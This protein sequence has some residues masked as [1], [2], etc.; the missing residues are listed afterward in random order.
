M[1]RHIAISPHRHIVYGI[2][3]R[4]WADIFYATYVSL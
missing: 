1:L 4:F 2:Q 3:K